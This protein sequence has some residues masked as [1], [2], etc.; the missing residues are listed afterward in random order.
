MPRRTQIF[1]L[2]PHTG[3]LNTSVE[4]GVLPQ[5]DLTICDN[6][7]LLASGVKTKRE[8]FSYFNEETTAAPIVHLKD[9]WRFT[10]SAQAQQ[11]V[12]ITSTP[13][14][15]TYTSGGTRTAA[16][17][18]ASTFTVTI[19]TPAVFTV[20]STAN[21]FVGMPLRFATTGALPTGL[22][23]STTYYVSEVTSGTEFKVSASFNST[24]HVDTTGSQSGTHSLSSVT[25]F[26]TTAARANS[27]SMNERL[28]LFFDGTNNKPRVWN[29][30]IMYDLVANAPQ[31]SFGTVFL[32]RVWTNDKENPDRV[33]YSATG[34]ITDWQGAS[35]SGAIDIR[36]GDGDS[37]GITAIFSFKGRLFVAKRNR[38]YQIA[39]DSPE[40]FQVLDVSSGLGIENQGAVAAV[41][42]NDVLYMSNK[43]MHSVGTTSAYGD[44]EAQFLSSKIQPSFNDWEL[45]RAKY[46]QAAY[47]P[48]LN[49]VVFNIAESSTNSQDNLWLYNTQVKEWYRWPNVDAQAITTMLLSG[50]LVLMIGTST[51]KIIRAQNGTKVDFGSTAIRYRIKTGSIYPDQNPIATKGLKKL[52]LFF[53]P[54][55]SYSFV[56]RVRVDGFQEQIVGFSG[57]ALGD[58]LGVDFRLGSSILGTDLPF[59]PKS[60]AI[61]G[62]GHGVTIDI[63]QSGTGEDVD[64]YGFALEYEVA[65]FSEE[66]GT[67]NE[68]MV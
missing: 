10:G 40:N 1:Q 38:L 7:Q 58:Q 64:I 35:D 42:Q 32:S 31:A 29:G 36:P 2:L 56:A 50:K 41:D 60:I 18:Q 27:V 45:A 66:G 46:T 48:T 53:K 67:S 59:S 34:S 15:Y 16:S 20:A 43:G 28:L 26:A 61:D 68:G 57:V 44:F 63:D 54:K 23:V 6:V 62:Y 25:A 22:A 3:G 8:G 19:A 21:Y 11:L 5:Q 55:S 39:G 47:V 37:E 13:A 49:S 51:G 30:T 9:Y 4:A 52:T 33:H 12:A 17:A 14:V 24:T 65:D